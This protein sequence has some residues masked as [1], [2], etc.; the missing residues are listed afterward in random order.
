MENKAYVHRKAIYQ[1]NRRFLTRLIKKLDPNELPRKE[2]F[3][4]LPI[5]QVLTGL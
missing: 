2:L 4:V 5:I 3:C 1:Q